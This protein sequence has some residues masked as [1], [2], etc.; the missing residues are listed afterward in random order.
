MTCSNVFNIKY[1]YNHLVLGKILQNKM[2]TYALRGGAITTVILIARIEFELVSSNRLHALGIFN[3]F[4]LVI[5]FYFDALPWI[6]I[7]TFFSLLFILIK[8]YKEGWKRI[9]VLI[10]LNTILS[11]PLGLLTAFLLLAI[12]VVANGIAFLLHF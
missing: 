2:Y 8:N 12:S 11:I 10:G 7:T 1:C 6:S 5:D 3:P 4:F 9:G